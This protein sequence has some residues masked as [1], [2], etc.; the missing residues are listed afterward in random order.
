[1][2]PVLDREAL[3]WKNTGLLAAIRYGLENEGTQNH[4]KVEAC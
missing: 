2:H 4:T 3:P 1:M